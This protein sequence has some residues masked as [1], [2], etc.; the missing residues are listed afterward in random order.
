MTIYSDGACEGNPG[1]GGWAAVLLWCGLKKELSGAEPA[2]TNNRMELLA[3]VRSLEAL[4]EPCKVEFWTDSQYLRNGMTQWLRGWKA[5][6]WKTRTRQPV[7]NGDLWRALDAAQRG[8][9]LQ[10]RWVKGH[11]GNAGNERC[12]TLA[13]EAIVELR[14]RY[15]PD[16]LKEALHRFKKAEEPEPAGSLF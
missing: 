16:Q 7:K 15:R 5:N 11:A 9:Q 12:D 6:G 2:T 8:H 10:W 3:A 1:P 14:R 4:K 13:R